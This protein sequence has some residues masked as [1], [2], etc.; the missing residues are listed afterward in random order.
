MGKGRQRGQRHAPALLCERRDMAALHPP[1]WTIPSSPSG[2]VGLK[3]TLQD[4]E[5]G[6]QG[7][8]RRMLANILMVKLPVGGQPVSPGCS[9]QE[10]ALTPANLSVA[11]RL[12]EKLSCVR[13]PPEH[14]PEESVESFPPR[15]LGVRQEAE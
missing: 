7:K 12:R 11:Q 2:S 13:W 9:H 1:H 15:D 5:M 10:L 8:A 4:L 3:L 14:S 6:M